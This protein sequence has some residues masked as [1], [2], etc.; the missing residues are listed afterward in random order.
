[1]KIVKLVLVLSCSGNEYIVTYPLNHRIFVGL[2]V[3][4]CRLSKKVLRL[5]VEGR[6][7]E[8]EDYCLTD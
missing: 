1:M 5:S 7:K 8:G 6:E 2:A 3:L 4:F